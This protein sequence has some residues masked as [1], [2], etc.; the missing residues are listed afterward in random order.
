MR[1]KKLCQRNASN[2][3]TVT[4]TAS[5]MYIFGVFLVRNFSHLDSIKNVF[6]LSNSQECV[7]LLLVN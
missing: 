2:N 6:F 1:K 3:Y 7:E 5:K 4:T